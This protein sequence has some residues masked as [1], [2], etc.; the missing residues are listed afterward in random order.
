MSK[1]AST[2]LIFGVALAP[3]VILS[4]FQPQATGQEATAPPHPPT[5]RPISP[6]A[7]LMEWHSQVFDELNAGIARKN[8]DVADS[9]WL[10]AELANVNYFHS[11]KID[12]RAWAGEMRDAAAELANTIRKNRDF[13]RAR[14]IVKRIKD[15]CKQCHDMY[16]F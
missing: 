11:E 10:L 7:T 2:S 12:Y 16:K 15:T 4:G 1:S 13:N 3:I 9:A 6:R 5:F 14:E 8:V